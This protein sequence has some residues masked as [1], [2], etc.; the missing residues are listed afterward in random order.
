MPIGRGPFS[1]KGMTFGVADFRALD[2][3]VSGTFDIVLSCD[4]S[5]PHLLT[6]DDLRRA[7]HSMDAKLRRGGLL[8]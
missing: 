3:Q 8:L 5:L 4:N 7:I 1:A 6:E 2:T